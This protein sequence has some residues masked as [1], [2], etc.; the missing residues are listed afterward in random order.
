MSLSMAGIPAAQQLLAARY[1]A[2]SSEAK[3][4]CN[5]WPV[6]AGFA[7]AAVSKP[8]K[9][10][11]Y[12]NKAHYVGQRLLQRSIVRLAIATQLVE[13]PQHLPKLR[14]SA[15]KLVLGHG[16]QNEEEGLACTSL[17]KKTRS[18]NER[19]CT[20]ILNPNHWAIGP[21]TPYSPKLTRIALLRHASPSCRGP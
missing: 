9:S 11:K 15:W 16:K 21:R 10:I 18:T 8:P 2:T 6:S 3:S 7:G 5:P 20:I 1:S 12:G 19:E 14:S 17:I 4:L 13:S